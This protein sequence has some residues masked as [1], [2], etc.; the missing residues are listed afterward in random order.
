MVKCNRERIKDFTSEFLFESEMDSTETCEQDL[1]NADMIDFRT[2]MDSLSFYEKT[3]WNQCEDLIYTINEETLWQ[4]IVGEIKTPRGALSNSV[5]QAGYGCDIWKSIGENLDSLT[6]AEIENDIIN[7]CNKYPEVNNVI[8]IDSYVNSG[9]PGGPIKNMYYD[10]EAEKYR[11]QYDNN[12]EVTEKEHTIA[13]NENTGKYYSPFR[14]TYQADHAKNNM[15]L[16]KVTLDTI[17]GT[18]DGTL[19]IPTAYTS[20]KGWVP[21]DERFIR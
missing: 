9:T 12:G 15:L 10:S 8:G 1:T 17:Y 20:Q 11:I 7:T 3:E 14:D 6:I 21:A 4:C 19:R 18:F 16:I 5:G 2:E 13:Y